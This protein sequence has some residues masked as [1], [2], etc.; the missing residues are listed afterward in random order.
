[1]A[2]SSVQGKRGDEPVG[3]PERSV[4]TAS[5]I[6]RRVNL[7]WARAK[8]AKDL[9]RPSRNQ[10]GKTAWHLYFALVSRWIFCGQTLC[11]FF[12]LTAKK[13]PRYRRKDRNPG[14]WTQP[15]ET[16]TVRV[17]TQARHSGASILF[18][19][20]LARGKS[21]FE[22][23]DFP[24]VTRVFA[25][26]MQ[27]PPTV[28][29]TTHEPAGFADSS[30]QSICRSSGKSTAGLKRNAAHPGGVPERHTISPGNLPKTKLTASATSN[31]VS[32]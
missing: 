18:L 30:R 2:Q 1:M 14:N 27:I 5:G 6:G 9:A 12:W 28:Q 21:A 8:D 11:G 26:R 13:P 32:P 3:F 17:E 23:H 22:S 25:K 31:A 19:A 24:V 4:G 16:L 15:A 7:G 20:S 29:G 10:T